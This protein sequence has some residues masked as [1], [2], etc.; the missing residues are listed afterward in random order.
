M[1]KSWQKWQ[2]WQKMANGK[3]GKKWQKVMSVSLCISGA[4]PHIIVVFSTHV[5]NDDISN[6]FSH[7]FKFLIFGVLEVG[8]RARN[9]P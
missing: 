9:D 3:K 4:V 2:K 1:A 6:N 7:F 5:Y 8:P